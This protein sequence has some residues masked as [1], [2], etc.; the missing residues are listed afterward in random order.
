MYGI[1]EINDSFEVL[2]DIDATTEQLKKEYGS[3][4]EW[5]YALSYITGHGSWM[6]YITDIFK[7]TT[8]LDMFVGSWSTFDANKKWLYFIALKLYGAKD[9]WCLTEAI[10]NA[11]NSNLGL[12]S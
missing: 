12:S 8:N 7:N 11:D 9:N 4:E 10:K 2:C 1:K 6:K 3:E 5:K